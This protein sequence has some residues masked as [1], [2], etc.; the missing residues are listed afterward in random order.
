MS[1]KKST[2]SVDTPKA[3]AKETKAEAAASRR[4][5]LKIQREEL[6][7]K[8]RKRR[9]ALWGTCALVVALIAAL[10][11]WM[12]I[13]ALKPKQIDGAPLHASSTNEGIKPYGN[14]KGAP[15][16]IIYSDFQCPG[17][18]GLEMTF[19]E[20][21][22]KAAKNGEID[23]EM[24]TLTF[25]DA[26]I[27]GMHSERAAAAA[28]CG[29]AVGFYPEV[30]RAI[31]SFQPATEGTGYSDDILTKDVPE[32]VKMTK[33][34]QTAFAS[35]YA[36]GTTADFVHYV[37]TKGNKS[38]YE[39]ANKVSTPTVVVDDKVMDLSKLK[40]NDPASFMAAV[41]ETAK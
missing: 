34:Q 5:A 28:A 31:Y 9:I 1:Q 15:K 6:A 14:A 39:F 38:L 4:E 33:D 36:Q 22:F 13:K 2:D 21:I 37:N 17:C 10:V 8:E 11:A 16:V 29:D 40:T 26:N 19:G 41:K 30:Y 18:K 12:A 24:R 27:K 25:L 7:R 20:E 23:L 3:T 35:C 32:L